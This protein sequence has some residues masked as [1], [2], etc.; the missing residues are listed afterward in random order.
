[1][2]GSRHLQMMP[3]VE[4]VIN[5]IVNWA[6]GANNSGTHAHTIIHYMMLNAKMNSDK[7]DS[8]KVYTDGKKHIVYQIHVYIKVSVADLVHTKLLYKLQLHKFFAIHYY[9]LL[10]AH[11]R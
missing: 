10:D 3:S 9:V 11:D 4:H 6:M 1:M 5:R 7:E 8:T 2:Y